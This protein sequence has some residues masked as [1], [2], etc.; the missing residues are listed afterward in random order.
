MRHH[1]GT[2]SINRTTRVARNVIDAFLFALRDVAASP[3]ALRVYRLRRRTTR[4]N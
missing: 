1:I 2:D 3:G 4:P